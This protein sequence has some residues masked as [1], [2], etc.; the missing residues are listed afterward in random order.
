MLS[1]RTISFQRRFKKGNCHLFFSFQFMTSY[2]YHLWLSISCLNLF[3][4]IA[5]YFTT[6][7]SFLIIATYYTIV[8]SLMQLHILQILLYISELRMHISLTS[9]LV[10]V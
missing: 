5:T 7:T 1:G 8:I 10:S 4:T 9:Y 2:L 3:L 6:V